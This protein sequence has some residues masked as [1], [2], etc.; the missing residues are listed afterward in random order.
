MFEGNFGLI[1]VYDLDILVIFD[2]NLV[3]CIVFGWECD[4]LLEQIID[5]LWLFGQGQ[6]LQIKLEVICE[7]FEELCILC[8]QLQ[9][10]DGVLWQMELCFNVISYDGYNVCLLI[11][12]DC[13]VEDLVQLC[14][15]Q[16]LVWVEE[17]YELVCIGVWELDLFIGLGCYFNQVYCLFGCCLFEVCCWYCFDELLVLVDL[18]IVIQIEQLL[19]ELCFGELVQVDVLLLLLLMDGCVLMVYLCVVS[20]FDEVGCNCVL[21]M[22]QDVIECEQLWCLLCECEEQ[23]CELVWVLFDGVVIFFDEYVLYVNV[24]VVGLFGYGSYILLGE[25]LL[26]LVVVVDLS[27]V[28]SQLCVG[29]LYLGLGYSSVVVMQC[30]DGCSFYVGLV[31]GDVCYGG[32]DC[33]LLIVCD[34]SDFECICSVL[35]IS[36]C[37]LQVMVGWLFLLQEDECCVILCDLYDDIGQVIIVIKLLVYVVLEEDDLQ[38]CGQ[39]LVQIVSLV[40]I[41]VVKLCD[42]FILLCFLQLDVLGLEVVFS[43]QVWVLFCFLLVELLVEIELLFYC[44]DNSI[45]QVC[46]CIVQESLINV[47]CYVC[48]SQVLLQLCD[49]GQCGL[50]LQICDDGE[51]FDLDGLCGLGLIVMCECV[52][53]VGGYVWIEFV[54]GEGILVD[55]YFFYQVVSRVVVDLLEY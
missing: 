26:V 18:V 6:V 34:F 53:S 2:V 39:D 44:F 27:W 20:G 40:D 42:I 33:K 25:F 46:F 49:V 32:C 37:E 23:F 31:V 21:G 36:N 50:Y 47:L 41:I 7:V 19:V 15:D 55:V 43:W 24:W 14:C 22:L 51:G 11:V 38:W 48:V 54:Y 12:I 5:V 9:L 16:V 10:C 17:V 3:V 4:E 28:C 35:E 52:Q 1:F 8:V 45:E 13:I 30:G 29:Q